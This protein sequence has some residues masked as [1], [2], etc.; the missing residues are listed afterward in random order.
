[1]YNCSFSTCFTV[2]LADLL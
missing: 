2:I 1:M